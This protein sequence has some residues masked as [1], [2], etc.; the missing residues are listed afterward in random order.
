MRKNE[1]EFIA[2]NM[3]PYTQAHFFFQDIIVD[4][5]VQN[6]S[7][8]TLDYDGSTNTQ[9]TANLWSQ[10]DGVFCNA[11][12]AFATVITYS[13]SATLYLNDNYIS[14]NVNPFGS[15]TLNST[16]F[17]IGDVVTQWAI[18]TLTQTT[19][20][21]V[22]DN[23][24]TEDNSLGDNDTNTGQTVATT[25][26]TTKKTELFSGRVVYW[27]STAGVLCIT[28]LYGNLSAN[29]TAN[30]L[31]LMYNN[32]IA[33]NRLVYAA[34]VVSG[35]KF[36]NSSVISN[37]TKK[38]NSYTASSNA[39]T[40]YS[41]T[42][43]TTN[44]LVVSAGGPNGG[45]SYTNKLASN[46]VILTSNCAPGITGQY[47]Y[48]TSGTGYGQVVQITSVA[49]DNITLT[50]ASTLAP[51]PDSTTTYS[52]GTLNVDDYGVIAGIFQL[53]EA[54]NVKF[55]AGYAVFTITDSLVINDPLAT[56][57]AT[58]NYYSGSSLPTSSGGT[59]VL[60]NL[61]PGGSLLGI[62][63]AKTTSPVDTSTANVAPGSYDT[64]TLPAASPTLTPLAQI[65]K[66][67]LPTYAKTNYGIFAT[68]IDLWF[69]RKPVLPHPQFPV[70]VKL[71]EVVNGVPVGNEIATALVHCEDV[72][73]SSVPDSA[74]IGSSITNNMTSTR[75]TFPDPVYLLPD[76]DYAIVVDA[77]SPEYD[78][79]TSQIGGMDVTSLSGT[80]IVSAS[81]SVGN[82]FRSQ[83]SSQWTPI[84]NF[85]MM[86]VLNKAAFSLDPITWTFNIIPTKTPVL[87]IDDVTIK[88][89]S[90]T[91][92]STL[93]EHKI[94]GIIYDGSS[95][96]ITDPTLI[97]LPVG[98]QYNFGQTLN[99][100]AVNGK[101]RYLLGGNAN[102]MIVQ[103]DMQSLDPDVNPL[104][105]SEMLSLV[106]GT[107]VINNGQLTS[108]NITITSPG[109]HFVPA[110]I[111][112]IIT[113]ANSNIQL[114][115]GAPAA[116]NVLNTYVDSNFGYLYGIN[117]TNPG[118]GYV[119][120]PTTSISEPS[121]TV[122]TTGI[123]YDGVSNLTIAISQTY[124]QA[125][126]D[127]DQVY[128]PIGGQ[129]SLSGYTGYS[130]P[131][132]IKAYTNTSINVA[133]TGSHTSYPSTSG[134]LTCTPVNATAI[135]GG[136]D[137]SSGG[138]AIARYQTKQV[139]L[140]DGFDSGDLRVW[141][142][143]IIPSGTSV[144]VYYKV[145]SKSDTDQFANKPWILMTPLNPVNSPDQITI[146]ENQYVPSLNGENPSGTLS[147]TV[148]NVQYPLGGTFKYFAIKLVLFAADSSVPPVV[149][150]LRV[151]A[152][153][154]G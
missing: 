100:S 124:W 144:Q 32:D 61:K 34:N 14:I 21:V 143:G 120:S 146:V 30:A 35:E 49:A 31:S 116:A 53:P 72:K 38:F 94:Q 106:T 13:P 85:Q 105:N 110:N 89:S 82:F 76:T 86:F 51:Y 65:F 33:K 81:P 39:Y 48:L 136:E 125:A 118:S 28:P 95:S 77:E 11:T 137:H 112:V 45:P 102:S 133:L 59:P 60:K 64:T 99:I 68:S 62:G 67:P 18:S 115:T 135:V 47:L 153:P 138:N 29:N 22:T 127:A 148:N 37:V 92:S 27:N 128:F 42:L 84:Q 98:V 57:I 17:A 24:A 114:P 119:G 41:G 88:S 83:N 140:A 147:Y 44:N 8:L 23:E 2:Q 78:I 154:A 69:S 58:Q 134:T 5:F 96:Y 87:P 55:P 70:I 142:D 16:D 75:F 43:N 126:I 108:N 139:I 54:D 90:V 63:G 113:A 3:N 152:F 93:L 131:Y 12:H 56:M 74:N 73:V 91:Y 107:N 9:N 111:S 104:F 26:S 121:F 36:T 150:G 20:S 103:I 7:V 141:L 40:N 4:R 123:T 79:W 149:T 145:M 129:L 1:I 109:T 122:P 97:Q 130:G 15:N 50:L 19:Y 80:R 6:P 101:T 10:G 71:V 25:V 117:F 151:A 52:T 46:E 132:T 66:T